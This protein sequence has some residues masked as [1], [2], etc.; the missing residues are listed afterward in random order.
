MSR[1][2][3]II[4]LIIMTVIIIITTLI[5]IRIIMIIISKILIT[6]INAFYGHSESMILSLI[7]LLNS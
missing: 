7:L 1:I 3:I 2:K 4:R 5:M 6:I